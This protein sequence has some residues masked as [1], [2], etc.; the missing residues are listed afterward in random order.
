MTPTVDDPLAMAV[1]AII[2]PLQNAETVEAWRDQYRQSLPRW[3]TRW[4]A[5]ALANLGDDDDRLCEPAA[6]AARF[7]QQMLLW[8]REETLQA[9]RRGSPLLDESQFASIEED[10]AGIELCWLTLLRVVPPPPAVAE[11]AAWVAYARAR[12]LRWRLL[13]LGLERHR[14][15]REDPEQAGL[16]ARAMLERL[17]RVP[18]GPLRR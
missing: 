18:G 1:V 4:Q 9:A 13:D 6:G 10:I 15:P 12:H 7:A 11:E 2:D 14:I 16:R 5:H 17:A 3:E 8:L